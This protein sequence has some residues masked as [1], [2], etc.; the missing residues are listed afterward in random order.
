MEESERLTLIDALRQSRQTFLNAL[1]GVTEAEAVAKPQ[2]DRW[3]ILECAEHVAFV[4]SRMLQLVSNGSP[5]TDSAQDGHS[6]EERF[7]KGALDRSRKFVAPELARP[8]GRFA[9]VSEAVDQ[10]MDSRERSIR[11]V[12]SCS[13]DLRS[14]STLHPAF[15]PITCQECLWLLIGHPVRHAEQI[16]EI[17]ELAPGRAISS[18]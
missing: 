17:R 3:S 11:Y 10:F 14:L 12:E 13:E 5:I 4:E 16:R 18:E 8:R 2:P 9:S 15:G 6:R 7:R 1:E